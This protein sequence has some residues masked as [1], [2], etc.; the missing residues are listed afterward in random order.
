MIMVVDENKQKIITAVET[1][2]P[3]ESGIERKM[4]TFSIHRLGW[5]MART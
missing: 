3:Y 4:S 2:G 5:L 1:G